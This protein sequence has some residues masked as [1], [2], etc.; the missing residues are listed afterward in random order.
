METKRSAC[1]SS[2]CMLQL[3]PKIVSNVN[4]NKCFILK[5]QKQ[6]RQ[7]KWKIHYFMLG[8]EWEYCAYNDFSVQSLAS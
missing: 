1:Y 2:D 4:L 5:R 6:N 7:K 8:E 3:F